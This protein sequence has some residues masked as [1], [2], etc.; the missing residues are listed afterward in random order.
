MDVNPY[1]SP[2]QLGYD[3]P[4]QKA[5]RLR[6]TL[7]EHITGWLT[8]GF[9]AAVT[10]PMVI[11]LQRISAAANVR[12]VW[13]SITLPSVGLVAVVVWLAGRCLWQLRRSI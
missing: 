5:P 12:A 11:H 9:A 1:E 7:A 2:Q 13:W 6:W 4:Q 3:P 10:I 8:T